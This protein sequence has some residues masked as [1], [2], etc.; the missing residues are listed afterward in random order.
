MNKKQTSDILQCAYRNLI[1]KNMYFTL[2]HTTYA[3]QY[4]AYM[5]CSHRNTVL[6]CLQQQHLQHFLTVCLNNFTTGVI[7][8][9]EG[10]VPQQ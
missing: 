6:Y 3:L 10:S 4:N 5:L 1:Y 7:S 8:V 2:L 9:I